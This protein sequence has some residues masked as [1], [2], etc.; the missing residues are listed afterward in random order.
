LL[1]VCSF[2]TP[3]GVKKEHTE[4]KSTIDSHEKADV[5]MIDDP[6]DFDALWHYDDPAATEQQFRALLPRAEQGDD[7][8]Y[9]AQ[10]RSQRIE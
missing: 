10:L 7:R 3:Q 4:T 2:F 5:L 6:H 1:S 9:H 8:S